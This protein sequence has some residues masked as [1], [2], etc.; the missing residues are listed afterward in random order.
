MYFNI[1][2][3]QHFFPDLE[4]SMVFVEQSTEYKF[5]Y[6]KKGKKISVQTKLY[7]MVL[8]ILKLE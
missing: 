3:S 5:I 8:V 1:I 4:M 7:I 6:S 2:Y